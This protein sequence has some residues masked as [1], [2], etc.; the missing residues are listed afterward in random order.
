LV[1]AWELF[2]ETID[3]SVGNGLILVKAGCASLRVSKANHGLKLLIEAGMI[4]R[5]PAFQWYA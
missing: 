1:D 4:S 3:L 5:Y 2:M